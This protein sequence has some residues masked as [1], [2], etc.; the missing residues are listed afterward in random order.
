M[1]ARGIRAEGFS[2]DGMVL[3]DGIPDGPGRLEVTAAGYEGQTL[4]LAESR[5]IPA[6]VG[7]RRTGDTFLTCR[8]VDETG[9]PIA[10]AVVDLVRTYPRLARR[11][12][13]TDRAGEATIVGFEPGPIRFVVRRRGYAPSAPGNLV[14]RPGSNDLGTVALS[15]GY[16]INVDTPTEEG[17]PP[18]RVQLRLFDQSG[19]DLGQ[20]LDEDSQM[21]FF[22]G[23]HVSLGPVGPGQYRLEL[24]DKTSGRSKRVDVVD[25]DVAVELE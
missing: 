18:V 9:I 5:E 13:L 12:A 19:T 20:E 4:E 1:S 8:V 14:V 17:A 15:R 21:V 23:A 16:R 22:R 24:V 7:L 25:A 6:E 3:L 11:I 10:Q 2:R